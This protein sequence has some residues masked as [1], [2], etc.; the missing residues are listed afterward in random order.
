[1]SVKHPTHPFQE[2]GGVLAFLAIITLLLSSSLFA[3]ISVDIDGTSG[4]GNINTALDS[5]LSP[6]DTD[7]ISWLSDGTYNLTN[8]VTAKDSLTPPTANALNSSLGIGDG[9]TFNVTTQSINTIN[10][11]FGFSLSAGN[12]FV[13]NGGTVNSTGDR[14]AGITILDGDFI[15][16]GGTLNAT[17]TKTLS[18]LGSGVAV[19]GD[20]ILT[21]GTVNAIANDSGSWGSGGTFS[22]GISITGQFIQHAGT[23]IAKGH[24]NS[25]GIKANNGFIMEGGSINASGQLSDNNV[26]EIIAKGISFNGDFTQNGGTIT[27]FGYYNGAG[28]MSHVDGDFIQNGGIL[29]ATGQGGNSYYGRICSG[30]GIFLQNVN[31]DGYENLFTFTTNGT[32]YATGFISEDNNGRGYGV[33]AHHIIQGENGVLYLM[34]GTD[35]SVVSLLSSSLSGTTLPGIDF[36]NGN[37]GY[38]RSR[39]YNNV[40]TGT[41]ISSTAKL[42]PY[43]VNSLQLGLN[44]NHKFLFL[45]DERKTLDIADNAFPD[46][47]N[48]ITLNYTATIEDDNE[49][50]YLDIY[51]NSFVSDKVGGSAK[52]IAKYLENNIDFLFDNAEKD[53]IYRYLIDRYSEADMSYTAGEAEDVLTDNDIVPPTLTSRLNYIS[54]NLLGTAAS[55]TMQRLKVYNGRTELLPLTDKVRNGFWITPTGSI[56]NFNSDCDLDNGLYYSGGTNLG[57]AIFDKSNSGFGVGLTYQRGYYTDKGDSIGTV[58]HTFYSGTIGY[59]TNPDVKKLWIE[60]GLSYAKN[61]TDGYGPMPKNSFTA[62]RGEIKAGINFASKNWVLSPVLGADFTRYS[63][64]NP[65][66]DSEII[67][68]DVANID[69][70]RPTVGFE[71]SY[72]FTDTYT[73]N[74]KLGYSYETMDNTVYTTALL[75]PT[76]DSPIKFDLSNKSAG[77]HSGLLGVGM[78][79]NFNDSLSLDGEYNLNFNKSMLTNTLRFNMKWV[80]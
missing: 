41:T 45:K 72:N 36:L 68:I 78:T 24:Y 76:G 40:G 8:T 60:G 11:L 32:V 43:L 49:N 48:T 65:L 38:F 74:L 39:D 29:K 17:A 34:P 75:D 5:Y 47:R 61:S 27:A 1:M 62:Y 63:Y 70:L 14:N 69:S 67:K 16:N 73:A 79:Y 9:V 23:V 6:P 53:N 46:P 50:Y 22:G 13:I 80:F 28:I 19:N 18:S 4:G 52:S 2:G 55:S 30:F 12:D 33:Y 10:L 57:F 42:V 56:T 15:V 25:F 59:R 51:R 44:E 58:D 54:E 66:L 71:A 20:F 77:R 26:L 37:H 3:Q 21:N 35:Y 31:H 7:G 64:N